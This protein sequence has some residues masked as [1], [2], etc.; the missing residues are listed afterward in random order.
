[1]RPDPAR[2]VLRAAQDEE[3]DFLGHYLALHVLEV[4]V[5]TALRLDE[6]GAHEAASVLLDCPVDWRI[7][8]EVQEHGVARLRQ[9]SDAAADAQDQAVGLVQPFCIY[10]PAVAAAHPVLY[11]ALEA[12]GRA[13]IAQ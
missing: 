2:R 8:R 6:V 11:L 12:L 9:C 7:A 3:L 4:H 10:L 13:G 1:A 5:P